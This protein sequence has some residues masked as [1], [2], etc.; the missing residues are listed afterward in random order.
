MNKKAYQFMFLDE[1]AC[2][3]LRFDNR[4]FG[5]RLAGYGQEGWYIV[6][7]NHVKKGKKLYK[8]V[9]LQRDIG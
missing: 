6:A 3:G 8:V 4:E 7:V 2:E 1:W 9:T 5:E